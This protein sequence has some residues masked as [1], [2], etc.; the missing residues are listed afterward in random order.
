M[1]DLGLLAK[2]CEQIV[3]QCESTDLMPD[4]LNIAT[5]L[6]RALREI[7]EIKQRLEVVERRLPPAD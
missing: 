1:S 5:I 2:R 4:V 6:A 3:R 7:E